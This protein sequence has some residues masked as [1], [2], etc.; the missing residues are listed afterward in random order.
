MHPR[1]DLA[2]FD[3]VENNVVTPLG[4]A[5]AIASVVVNPK[6]NQKNDPGSQE[7]EENN[8]DPWVSHCRVVSFA[9][10]SA[11]RFLTAGFFIK[12]HRDEGGNTLLGHR[13]PKDRIGIGNGAL[14]VGDNEE[15]G[16][17]GK[18]VQGF[19]EAPD[20]GIIQRGVDFIE[21]TKRTG[22]HE[23]DRKEKGDRGHGAL[24]A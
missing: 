1:V 9:G 24:A 21:H 3:T 2:A 22:L 15:L 12:A 11:D 8:I 10:L 18:T 7:K 19:T 6:P 14:I 17:V 4:L 5:L 20:V 23:I 13:D 16:F